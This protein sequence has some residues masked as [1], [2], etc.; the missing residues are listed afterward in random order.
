[1]LAPTCFGSSLPS[2]GSFWIRLSYIKIQTD[3]V[4]YHIMWLS[5]LCVGVS[6][7]GLLCFPAECIQGVRFLAD[8]YVEVVEMVQVVALHFH[9]ISLNREVCFFLA[10]YWFVCDLF[11]DAVSTSYC[12]YITSIKCVLLWSRSVRLRLTPFDC[13][14]C[15]Y[16]STPS[17]EHTLRR[18]FVSYC[19]PQSYCRVRD[20]GATYMHILCSLS[21]E[22]M[23]F[24]FAFVS[25]GVSNHQLFREPYEADL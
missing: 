22:N 9:E 15:Q 3:M 4:V 8:C 11:N 1:M 16:H 7:F 17:V 18:S 19:V 6:W 20:C 13:L 14:C 21:T 5:G 23:S 2:S 10:V 24:F 12:W 25:V